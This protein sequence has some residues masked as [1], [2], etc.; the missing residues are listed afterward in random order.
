MTKKNIKFNVLFK[1]T[2]NEVHQREQHEQFLLSVA[3]RTVTR[4][5]G[6]AAVNFRIRHAFK[7]SGTA[8]ETKLIKDEGIINNKNF[9]SI[10]HSQMGLRPICLNGRV[11]P[12]WHQVDFPLNDTNPVFKII[13]F[14]L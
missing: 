4:P 9:V 11:H 8:P 5:F 12:G 7:E 1:H 14:L 13:L 10:K 3:I 6:K 2:L